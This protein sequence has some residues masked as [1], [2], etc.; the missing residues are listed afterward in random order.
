M[1]MPYSFTGMGLFYAFYSYLALCGVFIMMGYSPKSLEAI[2]NN[3]Q[4]LLE[5]LA[6]LH[7]TEVVIRYDGGGDSGDVSEV[8]VLPENLDVANGGRGNEEG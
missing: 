3:R 4:P 7:V 2:T 1:A 5:A 8:S 6:A